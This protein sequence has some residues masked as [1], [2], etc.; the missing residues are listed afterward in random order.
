MSGTM[1]SRSQS[2]QTGR[3][4][5]VARGTEGMAELAVKCH[6]RA[7]KCLGQCHVPRIVTGQ[8]VMQSPYAFGKGR[9]STSIRNKPPC[10]FSASGW[11]NRPITCEFCLISTGA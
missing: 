7:S 5:D 1:D 6:Q 4:D 8:V 10:A 3:D 2:L 9:D 11:E